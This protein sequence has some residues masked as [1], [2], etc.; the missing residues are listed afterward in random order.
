M[1]VVYL[2]VAVLVSSVLP[3]YSCIVDSGDFLVFPL[4]C[5][6]GLMARRTKE[7]LSIVTLTEA[8]RVGAI[9]AMIV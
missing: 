5:R 9:I 7:I 2:S 1:L 8:V 3:L 6:Q 4:R